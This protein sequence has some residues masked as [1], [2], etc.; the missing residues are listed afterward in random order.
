MIGGIEEYWPDDVQASAS[1]ARTSAEQSEVGTRVFIVHGR[2]DGT[3]ETVA[4]F[5]E[6]LGLEPVILQEQPTK[7]QTII[8]KFEELAH[9]VAYAIV[10]CTPDDVGALAADYD[11]NPDALQHRMRQNVVFELGFFAGA[12]GRK[13]VCALVKGKI[14]EPS[15]YSGVGYI[16]LDDAGGW[17]LQ[18]AKELHSAGLPVDPAALLA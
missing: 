8:E 7:G 6:N 14:E 18:L 2:D 10:L 15:D 3:K 16:Q 11:A 9:P 13:R 4:R 1:D 17:R 12:K 5:L